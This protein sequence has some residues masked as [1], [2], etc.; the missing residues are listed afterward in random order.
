LI[1]AAYQDGVPDSPTPLVLRWAARIGGLLL[2]PL[3]GVAAYALSLRIGQYGLTPDRIIAAAC[4]VAGACYA[5][6]Y[7]VAA[8]LPG[9]WM[10]VLEVTNVV[11]AFVVLGLLLALFSP[12]A[13]PARLSVD[14][15]MAR[16][17]A[18]KVA[19]DKV[20]Y[21]FLRFHGER[22][23]KAALDTLARKGG[24]YAAKVREARAWE[25]EWSAKGRP[26]REPNV[27]YRADPK[28]LTVVWP[29]GKA[30]PAP[31]L[32]RGWLDGDA[33]GMGCTVSAPCS[34][35]LVDLNGDGADEVFV[36]GKE[37][38][39]VLA[40]S[41]GDEWSS[42]FQTS[43]GRCPGLVEALKAGRIEVRASEWRDLVIGDKRL[44][45]SIER[46]DCEPVTPDAPMV[47][48][49][50]PPPPE[51]KSRIRPVTY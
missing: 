41:V 21:G 7:G 18:G 42:P 24:V 6:G 30:L 27:G 14:D 31:F 35:A 50:G 33:K 25:N 40:R 46:N 51:Q 49:P 48:K 19:A 16:I 10:K 4:V 2:I 12:L 28:T 1:N 43:L 8:V 44:G 11:T 38:A 3:V 26:P 39:V 17:A 5:V 20:D 22:Y 34:V 15:Q 32:D 29:A 9:M 45:M 37:K 13:D 36:V 47:I 23:G